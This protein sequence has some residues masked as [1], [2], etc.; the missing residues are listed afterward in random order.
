[1]VAAVL[2]GNAEHLLHR[3]AFILISF[4]ATKFLKGCLIVLKRWAE[5]HINKGW[6]EAVGSK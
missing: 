5:V 4:V 2:E 3:T 1:M 6:E